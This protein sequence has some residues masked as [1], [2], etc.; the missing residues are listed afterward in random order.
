M[1]LPHRSAPH[2]AAS[3][4]PTPH[5]ATAHRSALRP[6][7]A[8]ISLGLAA[9]GCGAGTPLL[10]PVHP[11]PAKHFSATA[12][13]SQH[14]VFGGA[15]D[16]FDR[17]DAIGADPNGISPAEEP[18]LLEG[19]VVQALSTPELAPFVAGRAG[20][21]GDN[22]MGVSYTGRRV[23]VDVRHA[24]LFS[25]KLA[26]SLGGGI[27]GLVPNVG[28]DQ[29]RAPGPRVVD[30]S[31]TGTIGGLDTGSVTGF[32]LDIPL[33]IGWRSQPDVVHLWAGARAFFEHAAADFVLR[34]DPNAEQDAV[35]EASAQRYG[36]GGLVGLAVGVEPIWV[37]AEI[38][39]NTERLE[40]DVTAPNAGP[41]D[42]SVR[43]VTLAPAAALI[44][45]WK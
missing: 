29:P 45:E 25:P 34:V 10:H 13:L 14:F 2:R 3:H 5:R 35:A 36:V 8:S 26:L 30:N 42:L 12:G 41:L 20:L 16:A 27:S 11:L 43:G 40:A 37:A 33:L 22:E 44:V 21:P 31:S 28:A 24:F 18:A 38:A 7:I 1:P 19:A 15:R 9:L 4:R 32:G 6:T 17:A 39:A 23:R